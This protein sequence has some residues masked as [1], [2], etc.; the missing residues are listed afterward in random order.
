M[1]ELKTC[2]PVYDLQS[3]LPFRKRVW[4]G[5]LE[6]GHTSEKQGMQSHE[7]RRFTQTR[8]VQTLGEW[9]GESIRNS[10]SLNAETWHNYLEK[11]RLPFV[12]Y[13]VTLYH[14]QIGS[15]TR[16]MLIKMRSFFLIFTSE[17]HQKLNSSH[18]PTVP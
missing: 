11:G 16:K 15:R 3:Y 12:S 2:L 17:K 5:A 18:S 13:S 8:T 14:T 10:G 4:A 9:D 6:E 1:P 7:S